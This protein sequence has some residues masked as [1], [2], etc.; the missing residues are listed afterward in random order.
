MTEIRLADGRLIRASLHV[1]AVKFDPKNPNNLDVAYSV[2]SEVMHEPE[3]P[4]HDIH[5]TLQ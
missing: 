1:R 2:V 3:M 5:E 4:S